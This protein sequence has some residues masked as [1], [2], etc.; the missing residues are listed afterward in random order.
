MAADLGQAYVQIIPKAEG[1][2]S[3][4]EGLLS[5]ASKT[6]GEKAGKES[7][8][9]L[10][11]SLKGTLAKLAIGA[12]IGA[13]IKAALSEGGKLQQSFGGIDTL[14]GN[15]TESARAAGVSVKEYMDLNGN[16]ADK[17]KKFAIEAAKAGI[18]AN[19]YAEQAV[20]FGAGLKQAF[21]G[22]AAKAAEAAN[23]AILDMADNA[24]KMGTPLDQI[25][26]A[27]QGFAKQ[28][29]TM[30][31]N[32]K[33]GYGGTKSEMERLLADASALTGVQYDI[34][35]L[36][37]VYE[38]IHAIQGSLGLTG[39]AAA[40][41]S[42]TF[43]G[44]FGAMQASASNLLASLTTG[45][46]VEAAME[47]L[48]GTVNAFV[49]NNFIPM[50]G[51]MFGALPTAL[52]TGLQTAIPM[53]SESI[54][55][56][57]STIQSMFTESLPQLMT[58]GAQLIQMISEGVSQNLPTLVTKGVE[59]IK[60]IGTGIIAALP[61]IQ[62][63]GQAIVLGL[64]SKIAENL[65]AII[66]KGQEVVMSLVTGLLGALPDLL[67]NAVTM[68]E[69]FVEI[70]VQNLPAIAE[71]GGE[72]LGAL[73]EAIIENIPKVVT[74]VVQLVPRVWTA[75]W[76]LVEV[77]GEAGDKF[78]EKLVDGIK[79]GWSKISPAVKGLIDKIT[80][81]LQDMVGKVKDIMGKVMNKLVDTWN[82][83]KS[84]ASSIW[85]GIKSAITTPIE[86]AKSTLDGI[87]SKIR[88]LFPINFG[89]ILHFSLPKISVSGGT[90]PWGLGGQGTKPS[91]SVSWAQHFMG[92]I[93]KGLTLHSV[94]ERGNEAIV[95][96]QDPYM[97]PFAE[98]IASQMENAGSITNYITVDGAQ[99]PV[100]VVD[101]LLRR[102]NMKVR[103]A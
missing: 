26:H 100:L 19:D 99:D 81:P 13:G 22:D 42:G 80:K 90:P 59:L 47:T 65:P 28:N 1:I 95:P 89:K 18:S 54:P 78:L 63:K 97:K 103:T 56:V 88:G 40:E 10:A 57:I 77:A 70:I 62:E 74:A 17:V 75:F 32:L 51:T 36:G 82:N 43:T 71:A 69:Q 53:I 23:V 79:R 50:L 96:L 67:A 76:K 27:Y 6:A 91:F 29:Y 24:A 94:G 2:S 33:L 34:G 21:G 14:Y 45:G 20:S 72:M 31:D 37:D 8:E 5:P 85:E 55:Q 68:L 11:A 86:R 7:A 64:V 61:T 30:L 46:D 3:K 101:E 44:S 41:A 39:V 93:A 12:T 9:G 73:A 25:Q 49:L 87:V 102:M 38:A 84:K 60:Q 58:S 52:A 66:Q 48:I 83:I 16:A 92:G 35:N 15:V 98:S 4:I